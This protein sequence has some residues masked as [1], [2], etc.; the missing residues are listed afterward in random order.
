MKIIAITNQKGGVGKT[1][2]VVNLAA[3]IASHGFKTLVIDMDPQSNATSG[4]GCEKA[5]I[6]SSIYTALMGEKPLKE[7]MVQTN[8][9]HLSLVPSGID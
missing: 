3:A 4:F 9:E 1:T 5:D 2:T 7:V 8:I 6:D